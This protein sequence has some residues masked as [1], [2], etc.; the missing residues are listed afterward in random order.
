[1]SHEGADEAQEQ[2]DKRHGAA[3]IARAAQGTHKIP[4]QSVAWYTMIRAIKMAQ[5]EAYEEAA[6]VA[7]WYYDPM[8]EA[9]EPESVRSAAYEISAA[10]RALKSD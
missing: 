2:F 5:K 1:M 8:K 3:R 9:L 4:E 6:K 10:I 7:D